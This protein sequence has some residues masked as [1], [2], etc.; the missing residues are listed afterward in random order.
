MPERA[1]LTPS[2]RDIHVGMQM[3]EPTP[4]H[5][6]L[7]SLA[8]EWADRGV[9]VN[10]VAPT[11]IET[12]MTRGGMDRPDWLATWKEMT[13]MHR[14]GRPDEI[15]SVVLFLAS[16]ASSLMTGSVVVVDGGYTVC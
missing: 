6:K 15:A 7:E 10:A 8:G 5:K 1:G 12:A 9:R 13:P 14:V 16:A 11:Y 4:Q 2:T 3:P